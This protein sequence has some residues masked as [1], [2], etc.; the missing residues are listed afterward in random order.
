MRRAQTDA[1]FNWMASFQLA[2]NE[3]KMGDNPEIPPITLTE[4]ATDAAT[5]TVGAHTTKVTFRDEA[6]FLGSLSVALTRLISELPGAFHAS[7]LRIANAAIIR[8]YEQ[9]ARAR[10]GTLP[11]QAAIL[12][13]LRDHVQD[14]YHS[15]CPDS[16]SC[17]NIRVAIEQPSRNNAAFHASVRVHKLGQPRRF[18]FQDAPGFLAQ[19]S[20]ELLN[21]Q[22][23]L[24]QNANIAAA[25]AAV[26]GTF[27]LY[28]VG[29]RPMARPSEA[30]DA[31]KSEPASWSCTLL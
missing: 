2:Y 14:L 27:E 12:E 4:V 20:V 10:G 18:T 16:P 5:V 9:Q 30:V 31:K 24:L 23:N 6:G 21:I 7:T 22:V 11:P 3:E 19:L 1:T 17:P 8:A 15:L 25:N 13:G 26:I 29:L 28:V